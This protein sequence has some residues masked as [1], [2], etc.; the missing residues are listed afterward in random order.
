MLFASAFILLS[1]APPREIPTDMYNEFT[2][3]GKIPVYEWY[4][5]E[6]YPPEKPVVWT[7]KAINQNIRKIRRGN[8]WYYGI[9]DTWLYQA[10]EK[11]KSHFK[12][13]KVAVIGSITPWYESIVIHYG[14]KPV[15]IEYNKIT[16]N[17]PR[18]EVYTV[19]EF[20]DSD[21]TFDAVISISSIE[22]SGLGRY[23]D[24]LNPNGDLEAMA[25]IKAMLNPG[26][27]IFLAI[28]ICQDSVTFNAH[29]TYGPNRLPK[30][31]EGFTIYESIGFDKKDF[32]K[33]PVTDTGWYH[34]PI[35]ILTKD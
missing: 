31:L 2:D 8:T 34:Q 10:L 9:T 14:G 25:D 6:S 26:G 1:G 32:E 35:L 3:N 7:K 5:D 4:F 30:L 17:D 33:H 22:H 16:C 21:Q 28:P 19:E 23:G 29:R 15:T 18:V 13:K 24:D 20:K 27:L 11:H 12:G